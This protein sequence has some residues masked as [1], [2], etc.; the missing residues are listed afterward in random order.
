MT[1]DEAIVTMVGAQALGYG[2]VPF[3]VAEM[4]G[5]P[6]PVASITLHEGDEATMLVASSA[7]TGR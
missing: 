5:D 1:L 6:V 3:C 7:Y 4:D 2:G